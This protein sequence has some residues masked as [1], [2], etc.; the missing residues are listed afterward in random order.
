[1]KFKVLEVRDEGTHIPVLAIQM[2]AE[3]DVQAYYIHNRCGHPRDGTGVGLVKLSDGDGKFDPYDWPGRTMPVAH[4]YIIKHFAELNDGDVV[5]VSFI[6]G[7]SDQPKVSERFSMADLLGM[8][9][10]TKL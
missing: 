3:D 6:L 10:T 7:E 1:M 4:N 9:G 5:D 8:G 2:L